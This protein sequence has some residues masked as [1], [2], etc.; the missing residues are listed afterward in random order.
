MDFTFQCPHCFQPLEGPVELVGLD[1]PCPICRKEFKVLT[2][3]KP[4]PHPKDAGTFDQK[5][6]HWLVDV[7]ILVR[8]APATYF[9]ILI[10]VPEAWSLPPNGMLPE[11]AAEAVRKAISAKF[12]QSPV[13]PTKVRAADNGTMRRIGALSDYCN[14]SCKVWLLGRS[15]SNS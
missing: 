7:R 10:E 12:P 1:V 15:H 11:P 5:R 3:A 2:P 8:N 14:E 9:Q 6:R 13:T 4:A